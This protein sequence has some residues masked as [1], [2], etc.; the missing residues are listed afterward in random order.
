MRRRGITQQTYQR[1]DRAS[2]VP[3]FELL[4][5]AAYSL[6]RHLP[7]SQLNRSSHALGTAT[8]SEFLAFAGPSRPAQRRQPLPRTQLK[9]HASPDSGQALCREEGRRDRCLDAQ[10]CA[11]SANSGALD[12]S[13]VGSNRA[14]RRFRRLHYAGKSPLVLAPAQRTVLARTR[15]PVPKPQPNKVDSSRGEP[16]VIKK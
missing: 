15:W 12:M 9:L 3:R 5:Q 10:G 8:C 6:P 11:K 4:L 7:Q 14:F 16:G 2:F 1:K 13:T